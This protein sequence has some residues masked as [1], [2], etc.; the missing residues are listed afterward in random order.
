MRSKSIARKL[1][2]DAGNCNETFEPLENNT[3]TN[4]DS[5]EPLNYS[6]TN[7]LIINEQADDTDHPPVYIPD[8]IPIPKQFELKESKNFQGLGVW[9]KVDIPA[10]QKFGPFTGILKNEIENT[11]C[12]WEIVDE[13]HNV[14]GW[15][16]ASE[17]GAGNWMKYIRSTEDHE[18]R[19]LMA[20]QIDKQV[21]YRT[22]RSINA[23]EEMLLY[24][25]DSLYPE[26]D[27]EHHTTLA[28]FHAKLDQ[29]LGYKCSECNEV[30]SSAVNLKRHQ[31]MACTKQAQQIQD[32][33]SDLYSRSD[34]DSTSLHDGDDHMEH[35]SM[36]GE[37]KCEECPRSFQ[38]R[39][40]L[41]R[42]QI[43]HDSGKRY[44]CE[45]CD[46][47]FTDPSNLQ[48]HIRAQHVGARCHACT[49]C[50]KTFATSSG[51]KQ[52]Q[53]IHSSVKPFQCEVC[54]KAYTQFS[55][56]C[57]H[58]RMHADCRQQIKCKDC[59]QAFSTVTSLSKHK[60]FC[61]GALRNGMHMPFSAEKISPMSL[62]NAGNPA[63]TLNPALL[64]GMY[65]PPYPFYPPLGASY[66]V[67][68]GSHLPFGSLN[69]GPM[70]PSNPSNLGHATSPEGKA[71]IPRVSPRPIS[72]EPE[73]VKEER[74]RKNSVGSEPSDSPLSSSSEH[75][76]SSASDAESESSVR[77]H[78]K[79]MMESPRPVAFLPAKFQP[80]SVAQ[81]S[82]R[83]PATR[84]P[85]VEKTAEEQDTPFDLSKSS[86]SAM[87]SPDLPVQLKEKSPETHGEQPL[88]LT[89][90]VPKEV[91]P[92]DTRKTHIFGEMKAAVTTPESSKLH[93]AYPQFTN[94]LLYEQTL[95][96][97]KEKLSQC[98]QENVR[99]MPYARFPITSSPFINS[100][101]SP[102]GMKSENM[103]KTMSPILK[104]DKFPEQFSYPANK[105]K[106]RYSCK[107]CGKVFPRSANLTRHLRTHTGEQPY[108]CKYCERSFSI[109]SNLQ[110][111]VRN[112]HNKEKP[113]KCPLCDRCFGQQTN[114]DRHLKKHESEGP[115][116]ID[117]PINEPDL[118][119]KDESY[120]SEIRNFI[121][122]ATD[123]GLSHG[124]LNGDM[125]QHP[126]LDHQMDRTDKMDMAEDDSDLDEELEDND[127][128][129]MKKI[130][131]NQQVVSNNNDE[132]KTTPVHN[133]FYNNV[134]VPERELVHRSP[135][136]TQLACSS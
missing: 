54:L 6:P 101:I 105:L 75:D 115:N 97:D 55:N 79:P 29:D 41:I 43:S 110:R 65:R 59:G 89:Q 66:P 57:R 77:R 11:S 135:T 99:Y 103:D 118:D 32:N 69:N 102:Y 93:Y 88:D 44:N 23:A 104:M 28:S 50:G 37:F 14:K 134:V 133:G 40:N 58:K 92:I 132:G 76:G 2:H 130:C 25:N 22:V 107:F 116:V 49:E 47:I 53:H 19:N 108:K 84:S 46:K 83:S 124:I 74:F 100:P 131:L 113:F 94:Q 125:K 51:L 1:P 87:S 42:H 18:S 33:N 45:N 120:F 15:I 9:A 68:P 63:S 31:M 117:S 56:L 111:H 109:S 95:R 122:K 126:L 91:S 70:S 78:Q 121:G 112:I 64:M 5:E 72:A 80:E 60:R 48:R 85:V 73:M 129:Q 16:D 21:F 35:D 26:K 10:G 13:E 39:S 71:F 67:F 82:P 128:P 81:G 36:E 114:L 4:N 3:R 38:W 86:R 96:M 8:D 7:Q 30:F 127:E 98:L 20:I 24:T 90:K 27:I 17:P 34:E 12:A 52:H 61:E 62:H 123:S 136:P 106:E 119:E